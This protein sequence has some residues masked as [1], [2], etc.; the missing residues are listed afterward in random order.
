MYN[1]YR[2]GQKVYIPPK[3]GCKHANVINGYICTGHSNPGYNLITKVVTEDTNSGLPVYNLES[4]NGVVY[5]CA[6]RMNL[7]TYYKDV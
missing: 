1:L 7:N 6:I 4:G 5:Y 3:Q 2:E